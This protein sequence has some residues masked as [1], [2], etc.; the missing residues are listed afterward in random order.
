MS[1]LFDLHPRLGADTFFVADWP[2]ARVLLMNDARFPWLILV[3]RRPA[4]GDFDEVASDDKA[5]FQD[6]IRLASQV[7]RSVTSAEKLNVAALGNMVPQLHVHVVAR[8]A[9]DAAWPAPVWGVGE[10]EPYAPD[11]AKRLVRKIIYFAQADGG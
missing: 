1:D 5:A 4:L 10:A 8:F 11:V 2:L 3:P 9:A 7:L 6:E